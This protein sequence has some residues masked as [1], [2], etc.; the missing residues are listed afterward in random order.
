MSKSK[1]VRRPEK[2][3]IDVDKTSMLQ[4]IEKP[5]ITAI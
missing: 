2:T 4:K 1:Y 3:T 5:Q